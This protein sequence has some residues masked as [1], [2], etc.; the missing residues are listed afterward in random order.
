MSRLDAIRV[1][2]AFATRIKNNMVDGYNDSEGKSVTDE[3]LWNI[4]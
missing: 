1:I 3:D 4:L 2:N